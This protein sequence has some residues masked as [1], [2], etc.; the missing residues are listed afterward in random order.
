MPG[1]TKHYSGG[2]ASAL[3]HGITHIAITALAIGIAL[4]LPHAATY[5][6]YDWW[7]KVQTSS[8]L[9]FATEAGFSATLILLFNLMAVMWGNRQ[10]M[11]AARQASLVYAWDADAKRSRRRTRSLVRHSSLPRDVFVLTLTGYNT[12]VDRSSL[13]SEVIHTAYEIR[14]MVL[15]PWGKAAARRMEAIS[16]EGA[17]LESMRA[18]IAD[19]VAALTSLHRMGK[20]VAL[21]FYDDEPAW[22]VIVVG[23]HVWVQHC[24]HGVEMKRQPEYVFSLRPELP[25]QG[26]FVPFY[27][28]FLDSWN[29]LQHADFDFSTQ[30]MIWRDGLGKE[31]RRV[32]L[33]AIKG[34]PEEFFDGPVIIDGVQ[35]FHSEAM[36]QS[37]QEFLSISARDGGALQS[38]SSLSSRRTLHVS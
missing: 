23:D 18:E 29:K 11:A 27:T 4:S 24:H 33:Q 31:L 7:P 9:L 38:S 30:E 36:T 22:K 35:P 26:F 13:F 37:V 15:N 10:V 2:W 3:R 5:V 6:L 28:Y 25:R 14:V 19:T 12:F 34:P 17:D 1:R 20:K 21:K 32:P 16:E 8:G